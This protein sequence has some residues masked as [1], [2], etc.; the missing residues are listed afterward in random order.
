MVMHYLVFTLFLALKL[1]LSFSAKCVYDFGDLGGLRRNKVLS[2][3]RIAT[4]ILGEWTHCSQ[5]PKSG[6]SACTGINTGLVKPH[7]IWYSAQNDTNNTF[8]DEL[9]K[10]E[11]ETHRKPGESGDNFM[12]RVLADCTKMNGYVANVWCRV[13][14]PS[15]RNI[16]QR[17]LLSSNPVLN[18]I[19][20][21]CN[22]KY[23]YL[24]PFGLQIITHGDKQHFIDLEANSLR[25]DSPGPSPG[26][27][28]TCQSP[29]P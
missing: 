3:L 19:K 4:S 16:V 27:T 28:D 10:S 8:G 11:C 18:V 13:R 1:Q 12:G 17:I 22:A 29:L 9:F 7:R 5:P 24:T 15:Q 26:A 6:D 23:P 25:V 21:G 20:D 2:D 14:R